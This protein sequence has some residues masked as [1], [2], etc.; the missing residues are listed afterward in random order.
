MA[1]THWFDK[2][3]GTNVET[4]NTKTEIYLLKVLALY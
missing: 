3:E 2:Q 1:T 4:E